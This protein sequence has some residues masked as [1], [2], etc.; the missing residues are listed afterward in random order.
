M[1]I[2]CDVD[3]KNFGYHTRPRDTGNVIVIR[4]DRKPLDVEYMEVLCDWLST[5]L[6]P[7]FKQARSE[8]TLVDRRESSISTRTSQKRTVRQNVL[9]QITKQNLFAYSRGRLT[10]EDTEDKKDEEM[11]NIVEN[12]DTTDDEMPWIE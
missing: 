10:D 8:C 11:A 4:E 2:P 7:L 5:I 9:R 3:Q 12:E 1:T 6:L